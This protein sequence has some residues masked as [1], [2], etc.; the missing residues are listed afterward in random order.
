MALNIPKGFTPARKIGSNYNSGGFN[1]YPIENGYATAIGRGDPVK[2][3][4]GTIQLAT[5]ADKVLG[6]FQG[7]KYIDNDGRL[8]F[9]PNFPAGTSSKGGMNV[10]SNYRQPLAM[11]NDDPDQT[12]IL[13]ALASIS[14]GMLGSSF[15]V[16]AIGSVNGYTGRS[17]AVLDVAASAGTSGGHMVTILGLWTE[18]DVDWDDSPIAVEVKLSQPGIVGEL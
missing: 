16:S 5:N 1:T 17:N 18:A 6:V 12:Y 11:V 14:A 3:S 15:K 13:Q 4:A 7:S 10:E 2:L 8:Q 9:K